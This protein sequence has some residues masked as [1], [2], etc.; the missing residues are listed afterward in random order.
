MKTL[1]LWALWL[2]TAL[3]IWAAFFYA[4]PAAGFIGYSSRILYFHVPLAWT[5]FIAFFV[6]AYWS[7]RYLSGRRTEHD[8]AAVSAIEI[9]FVYC[10]LATVTGALWARI[11]WGEY[12]N[13]DPRQTSI[14]LVLIFYGAYLALRGAVPD[15]EKRARLSAVYALIGM[16][17]T[18]FF[19]FIVPRITYSLHPDS[20]I[21]SR[22][23]I[24]M[25][26]RMLQVLLA[27][28]VAQLAL[29]FWM[30]HLD[31]RLRDRIA[32]QERD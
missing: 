11:M 28:F 19:F 8:R 3:V 10:V 15:E 21:N 22:G 16:A 9:G 29:F 12:W 27:S 17:V 24:D 31:R 1:S 18:P 25:D 5:A 32:R 30:H 20:V 14:I 7:L 23:K 6:A 2:W 13:W 4:P 26:S